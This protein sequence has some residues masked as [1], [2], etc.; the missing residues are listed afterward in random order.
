[1]VD[2]LQI[3]NWFQDNIADKLKVFNGAKEKLYRTYNDAF[4]RQDKIKSDTW[5]TI[6]NWET[7][8]PVDAGDQEVDVQTSALFILKSVP[9]DDPKDVLAAQNEAKSIFFKQVLPRMK[10]YMEEGLNRK[11]FNYQS[12]I[13]YQPEEKMIGK[14]SGYSFEVI[15]QASAWAKIELTDEN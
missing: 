6:L 11:T 2:S 9:G 7:G 10:K 1:M 14:C 12:R 3:T 15:W 5:F 13:S 4:E 8:N